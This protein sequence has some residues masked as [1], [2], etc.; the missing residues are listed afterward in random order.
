MI[1]SEEQVRNVL[2]MQGQLKIENV[3][4]SKIP[5]N[6]AELPKLSPHAPEVKLV[7][8][9]LFNAPEIRNEKVAKLKEN[10]NQ[11]TYQPTGAHIAS[12][13]VNRSLVDSTLASVNFK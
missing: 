9:S 4:A 1:V 8:M 2:K 5:R 7:K 12:K 11:G 13:M 6:K 3:R 10:I